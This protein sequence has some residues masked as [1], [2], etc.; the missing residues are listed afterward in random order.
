[1]CSS[2]DPFPTQT[3]ELLANYVTTVQPHKNTIFIL[4]LQNNSQRNWLKPWM[5]PSPNA[6]SFSGKQI[7]NCSE[8]VNYYYIQLSAVIMRSNIQRLITG[9]ETEY[10]SDTGSTK[11]TPYLALMGELWRVFC[12]YFWENW[13]CYNGNALKTV[14]ILCE[15]QSWSILLLLMPCNLVEQSHQP[16]Y[17]LAL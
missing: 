3:T 2:I 16:A 8:W 5:T 10:Q 13:S 15:F 12:W 6:T 11:D 9:T 17:V 1:M 14:H 7:G 4:Q